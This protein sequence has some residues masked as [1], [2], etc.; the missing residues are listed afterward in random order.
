MRNNMT[1]YNV[2]LPDQ[3][4]AA[5]RKIAEEKGVPVAELIRRAIDECLEKNTN[6]ARRT[7]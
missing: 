1:K 6:P 2:Y 3:Q 4:I 5:L 7:L